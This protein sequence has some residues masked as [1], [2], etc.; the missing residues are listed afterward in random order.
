ML[1]ATILTFA[2]LPQCHLLLSPTLSPM[3][4]SLRSIPFQLLAV[5]EKP[6]L[7]HCYKSMCREFNLPW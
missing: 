4:F 6:F 3:V 1:V 2:L 5:F 7:F